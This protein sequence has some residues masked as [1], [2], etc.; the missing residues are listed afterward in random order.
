MYARAQIKV[1]RAED[2]KMTVDASH[3]SVHQANNCLSAPN[4]ITNLGNVNKETYVPLNEPYADTVLIIEVY[5]W[6]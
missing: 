5:G 1:I 4:H 2:A 3:C 6:R